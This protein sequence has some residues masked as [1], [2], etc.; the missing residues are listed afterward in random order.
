MTESQKG[1][2]K[3][4]EL[5]ARERDALVAREVLGYTDY[6]PEGAA[7][8]ME[9][10]P[11]YTTDIA[12]AWEVVEKMRERGL[13]VEVGN[14]AQSVGVGKGWYAFAVSP[15]YEACDECGAPYDPDYSVGATAPEAICIAALRA[16]GVEVET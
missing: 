12:A 15:D 9:R 4:A 5:S 13:L 11:Y 8:N 10:V 2:V 1:P 14:R 3:W 6:W 16:C 7:M